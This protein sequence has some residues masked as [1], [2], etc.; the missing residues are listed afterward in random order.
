MDV[1]ESIK[2]DKAYIKYK[3]VVKNW[4]KEF[5][6][7]HSRTP[8]KFDIKEA[9]SKIKYAYKKYFQ[10]KSSALENS[11]SI[12]IEDEPFGSPSHAQDFDN[13]FEA[14]SPPT[15]QLV[16]TLPSG[17]QLEKLLLNAP[18]K[19]EP[20]KNVQPQSPFTDNLSKKLFQNKKF[21]LRN[22]RKLSVHKSQSMIENKI[23]PNSEISITECLTAA[24]TSMS[25]DVSNNCDPFS[26][27]DSKSVISNNVLSKSFGNVQNS[28][29][30]PSVRQLDQGWL[31]RATG[32]KLTELANQTTKLVSPKTFG[33][34]NIIIARVDPG[35]DKF[36]DYVENSESEGE[37]NSFT[38]LKPALKKRKID[39]SI[40][41][42]VVIDNSEDKP[43]IDVLKTHELDKTQTPEVPAK[44]KRTRKTLKKSTKIPQGSTEQQPPDIT[45]YVPFGIENLKPRHSKPTDILKSV[46]NSLNSDLKSSEA[47]AIGNLENKIKNG[48]L[49]E[50]FVKINIEKKVFVRGKKSMNFS[51][52]KRQQNKDKKALHAGMEFPESG[53]MLCF[54]CNLPGHM[55]RYCTAHR[56]DALL[57]LESYSEDNIP[58][59]EDIEN[60]VS[61]ETNKLS[62][63]EQLSTS[64][65]EASVIPESFLKLLADN[66]T[67]DT[68]K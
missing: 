26:I 11:L 46:D 3:L 53:K 9:P 68:G 2:K 58:T 64:V 44:N 38:K 15:E 60:I 59:L 51:K 66:P 16:A 67:N 43:K 40:N 12:C 57:P 62:L 54:K 33:L 18:P 39:S 1:I 17:P 34:S 50:N 63:P 52:Y 7:S 61:K 35:E 37:D 25:I 27:S 48:T 13:A 55:A 47:S 23:D 19:Q 8:S 56:G 5:K 4:E 29:I 30:I 24:P 28:M 21:T 10:L 20:F 14:L 41:H 32:L 6:T 45:E 42:E 22:P 36:C 65:F 31:E 49:N